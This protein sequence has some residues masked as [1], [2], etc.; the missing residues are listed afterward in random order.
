MTLCGGKTG[1]G[2][3][4]NRWQTHSHTS[5]SP[6]F[7]DNTKCKYIKIQIRGNTN[8]NIWQTCTCTHLL[9]SPFPG[10][11]QTDVRKRLLSKNDSIPQDWTLPPLHCN[12]NGDL[13]AVF[14]GI[15]ASISAHQIWSNGVISHPEKCRNSK[16][17]LTWACK[18]NKS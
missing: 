11:I 13:N 14:G 15:F 17:V 1:S 9:Y 12:H 7:I 3:S 8:T 2:V 18:F 16:A 5:Y 6:F 4:L 10:P